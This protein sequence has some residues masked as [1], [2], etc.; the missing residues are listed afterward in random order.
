MRS[1]S[2][3]RCRREPGRQAL[4]NGATGAIGSAAVQLLKHLGV[5]VTAVCATPHVALVQSLGA[6][7]VI[8]YLNQDFTKDDARYDFVLDAV[9]KST[10][11]ACKAILK[12]G[13]VYVSSELG[14]GA[15][16]LYLALLAPLLAERG[17]ACCFRSRW[18]SRQASRGCGSW[19]S[20]AGSAPSST[21]PTAW[22][23]FARP[24]ATSPAARR[25]ET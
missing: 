3:A 20:R 2:C 5:H 10:F 15:E 19:W 12:P 7:R 25:S 11:G 8:D 22:M 23:T 18:T 13:G 21:G 4:V 9:G 17:S 14:P 24:S 6:D 1:I 16:N